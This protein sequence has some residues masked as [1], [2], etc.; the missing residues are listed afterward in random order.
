MST[1]TADIGLV[2]LAVLWIF[3]Q[4][5]T[6]FVIM[7]AAFGFLWMFYIPYNTAYMIVV[8]PSRRTLPYLGAVQTLGSSI[9]PALA[10]YA[11]AGNDVRGALAVGASMLALS[12]ILVYLELSF[13]YTSQ[14]PLVESTVLPTRSP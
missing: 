2:G 14:S 1:N 5:P 9:G 11:V 3:Y 4:T 10:S 7:T 12:I 8:D 13:R 6:I